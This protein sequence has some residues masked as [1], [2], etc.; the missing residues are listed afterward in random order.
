M[1]SLAGS[2]VKMMKWD[3]EKWLQLDTTEKSRNSTFTYFEAKTDSF[4]SFSITGLKGLVTPLQAIEAATPTPAIQAETTQAHV[5]EKEQD[6][7]SILT[8]VAVF[9]AAI[10]IMLTAMYLKRKKR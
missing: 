1:N 5:L 3:G 2:D 7:L 10:T 8:V 4:S 6:T 9:L